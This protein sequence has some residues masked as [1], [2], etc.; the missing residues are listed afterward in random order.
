MRW[1][2]AS[3]ERRSTEDAV[4]E[5]CAVAAAELMGARADLV[6]AF[7]SPHHADAYRD[8]PGWLRARFGGAHI[9]GCSAGG[10]IGGGRETE[11]RAAVSLLAAALPGVDVRPLRFDDLHDDELPPPDAAPQLVI[12]ADPFTCDADALIERLDARY[13]DARK[14][15]GLASGGGSPGSNVLFL[16]GEAHEDGAVGVALSGNI[17]VETI[18]AQ[19]CRP[20]GQPMVITRCE[21]NVVHELNGRPA[22][23]VLRELFDGLDADDRKLFR[24]SLHVG[25]EMKGDRVEYAAGDFLIRNVLGADPTS[26]ALAI[27]AL[28][29]R[30]Q[31]VQFHLRDA[32]TAAEDLGACLARYRAESGGT[33]PAGALLF[34][35]LGRGVHLYGRPN[36]DSDLFRERIGPVPVG[37]FFCNGEIGPVGGTTFLHGYTSSFGLFRPG[38]S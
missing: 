7:V 6:F 18:V 24:T 8:I 16:D 23:T 36:H 27:G 29:R 12:L 30:Y 13:P 37:G 38:R 4:D 10:V 5:A 19:G 2:S 3:S 17:R 35:C 1:A 9:A 32:R 33:R 11:G 20:I 14:V 21:Q 26:G 25:I 28:P 31:A 34:S 22:V 15:G